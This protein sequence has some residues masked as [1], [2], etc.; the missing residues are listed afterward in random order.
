MA[1]RFVA[2]PRRS[3]RCQAR[4][5]ANHGSSRIEQQAPTQV[6]RPADSAQESDA[7]YK[8]V[9]GALKEFDCALA[10]VALS[11][12]QPATT[13]KERSES[14]S[15][16]ESVILLMCLLSTSQRKASAETKGVVGT[17]DRAKA[18]ETL[19]EV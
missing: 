7:G 9:L 10:L 4:K 18:P 1:L 16:L 17:G 14:G 13:V 8:R 19:Q 15:L 12:V 11:R 6:E 2:G 5:A 3:A